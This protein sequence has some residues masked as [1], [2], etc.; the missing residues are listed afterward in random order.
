MATKLTEAQIKAQKK[1]ESNNKEQRNY[2]KTKSSCKSFI[3]NKATKDDI[4]EIIE[5]ATKIKLEKY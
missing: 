5:L 4:D 3:R 2:T 1:W